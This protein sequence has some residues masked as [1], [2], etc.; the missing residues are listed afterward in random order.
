MLRAAAFALVACLGML[1]SASAF[2]VAPSG[3]ALALRRAPLCSSRAGPPSPRAA[4]ALAVRMQEAPNPVR[5]G[6][7]ALAPILGFALFIE[8]VAAP[9]MLEKLKAEK[10]EKAAKEGQK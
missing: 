4:R 6:L 10:A 5:Q 7:V 9:L 1:G 2:S 8:Y 3:F